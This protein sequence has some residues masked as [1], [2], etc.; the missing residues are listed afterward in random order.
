MRQNKK[1]DKFDLAEDDGPDLFYEGDFSS[2][3]ASAS[4]KAQQSK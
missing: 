1:D 2:N 3:A 4:S